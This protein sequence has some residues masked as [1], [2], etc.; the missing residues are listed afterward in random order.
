MKLN[1]QFL[2]NHSCNENRQALYVHHNETIMTTT[3]T[4]KTRSPIFVYVECSLKHVLSIIE[5]TFMWDIATTD[6]FIYL[7]LIDGSPASLFDS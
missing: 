2:L 4:Q 7:Y 5:Q 3:L 1:S 6:I